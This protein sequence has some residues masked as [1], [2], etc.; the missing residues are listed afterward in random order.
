MNAERMNNDRFTAEESAALLH[1]I[2]PNYPDLRGMKP[3][4][5]VGAFLRACVAE[6]RLTVSR[7]AGSLYVAPA[8]ASSRVRLTSLKPGPSVNWNRVQHKDSVV[9]L[10]FLPNIGRTR[11]INSIGGP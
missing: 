2:Y 4:P 9:S 6:I 10:G 1:A 5:K 8:E 11:H 3:V 7:A